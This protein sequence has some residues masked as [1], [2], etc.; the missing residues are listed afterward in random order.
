MDGL[1]D[2]IHKR[3]QKLEDLGLTRQLTTS[4]GLID[5]SSNDYLGVN[6]NEQLQDK[7]RQAIMDS[8]PNSGSTG[9]RLLT[10]NS[11]AIC[12][13]EEQVAA[14]HKAE[15]A[16]IFNSG[17]C[18]NLGLFSTLG[19]RGVTILYDELVHASIHDGIKLSKA[20]SISFDH[21]DVEDLANKL[22]NVDGVAIVIVESIYSMDGDESP[23]KSIS[24]L[25]IKNGATLIV[26]E[27]HAIGMYG[28]KGEGKVVE[29]GL[30]NDV[31]IR[32]VTFGKA[33]GCHGAAVLC[34]DQTKRYLVNFSRSL[35]FTT[36]LPNHTILGVKTVYDMMSVGGVNKLKSS[37]L[38]D[39]FK[40]LMKG[41][42]GFS[43]KTSKSHIQAV[44]VPGNEVVLEVSAKLRELGFDVRAIRFP[45]VKKGAERLR[46]CLHEF[47]NEEEVLGLTSALRTI[48][49]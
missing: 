40:Q 19:Q 36:S 26:D 15:S 21:N 8:E 41:V 38:I 14:F 31:Q 49:L 5:F 22:E 25:C 44:I 32:L 33:I 9:S 23:L 35:I 4:E 48:L 27:A 12:E 37:D 10:G 11:A 46:I 1:N 18:A 39:L 24:N 2:L 16:L 6:R 47:N 13:L 3:L 28:E 30:E 42:S 43:D 29:L 17:Y 34:N 7:I 20:Q 45:S